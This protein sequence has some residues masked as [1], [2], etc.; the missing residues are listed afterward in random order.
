MVKRK[1]TI[2]GAGISGLVAAINLSKIGYEVEVREKRKKIGGPPNWHPSVHLQPFDL[3]RTSQYINI[4]L[5]P[6][7]NPVRKHVFYFYGPKSTILNP[8]NSYV[9]EKGP[10]P[11]SIESYLYSEAEKVGC[12]ILFGET[13]DLEI[14]ELLRTE[15]YKCIVATGLEQKAYRELDIK[16]ATIQGYR[17]SMPTVEKDFAISYFGDYTNHDFAYLASYGSLLFCLLFARKGMNSQNLNAF[18]QHLLK[19]ERLSFE[20]WAFSTGCVPLEKNLTKNGVV[21]AGTISGMIDPFYLNGISAA[22]ISGKIAA[23][24]FTD[25]KRAFQEFNR[26]TRNFYIKQSLKFVADK[27]PAKKFLFP[28]VASF[29]NHLKWVGVI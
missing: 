9:C 29:N 11:S 13:F 24:F 23:L 10:R 16:H 19:S 27:L 18:Q 26:F 8:R 28:L 2:F 4:D 15:T 6:C 3:E 14:I 12:R 1:I 20:D 5:T 21:L 25:K 7:F 17:A 22:L